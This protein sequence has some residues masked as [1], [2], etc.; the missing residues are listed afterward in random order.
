MTPLVI[1]FLLPFLYLLRK[2]LLALLVPPALPDIPY[3][4]DSS[5]I[6]GDIPRLTRI[7][8]STR[9]FS[10]FFDGACKDLGVICQVR[11]GIFGRIVLVTD[12]QEISN[13]LLYRTAA[14]DRAEF[15][16]KV[17]ACIF[18]AAL[19]GLPTNDVWRHHKRILGFAMT[20]KYLSLTTPKA[21]EPIK[22]LIELWKLKA[23]KAGG[24]SWDAMKDMDAATMDAICGMAFGENWQCVA[25]F[26]QQVSAEGCT[27]G[28]VGEAVFPH[29]LPMLGQATWT[30]FDS[31]PVLSNFPR[32]AHFFARQRPTYRRHAALVD[33]FLD[34]KIVKARLKAKAIGE[35]AADLAD[36]TLDGLVGR[37]LR[38]E[39]WMKDD[40]MKQEVFQYLVAGT[41]TTSAT[42]SWFV[43]YMTIHPEVQIKL[44]QHLLSVL[45]EI[46]DRQPTYEELNGISTPYLE[47]V[48]HE[49]LRLSRTAAGYV[50]EAVEDMEILGKRVPKGSILM[51]QTVTGLEDLSAPVSKTTF[52]SAKE[53]AESLDGVRNTGPQRK[54]GYWKEGT[55]KIFDPERWLD[56][57]GRF[58]SLA[59]PSLPFSLGQRGCFGKNLALLELR[60]FM[61]QLNQQFFFGAVPE[62]QNSMEAFETV[63]R[64]P[65][66]CFVRP[67]SWESGEAEAHKTA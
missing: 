56:A 29:V 11:F 33:R 21:N 1:L 31:I 2:P 27:E 25:S 20:S 16:T 47:A 36:N 8:K 10:T 6:V 19:I 58:D 62:N 38:G 67:L 61:A 48:V 65:V 35:E 57:Q 42:L 66:Q 3:Y 54:T 9:T 55:G 12:Y 22:D 26:Q 5:P 30:I 14:I 4:K 41:E 40:E 59:G 37:E 52:T 23:E 15:T 60:L 28:P 50:R 49:T 51:F 43:K 45:P 63:A 7:I 53:Q 32:I 64:H 46:Q 18:P 34:D 24:R 13:L 17:F 39:D 44:R